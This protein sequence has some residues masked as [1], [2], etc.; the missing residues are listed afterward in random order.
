MSLPVGTEMVQFPTYRLMRLYIQRTMVR[1]YPNR[2]TPFGYRRI[3]GC[4]PL[5]VAFRSLPRPS[6]PDSPKA[7]TMNSYS[8]DHIHR[9]RR[10]AEGISPTLR[11]VFFLRS[12]KCTESRQGKPLATR[13]VL[14]NIIARAHIGHRCTLHIATRALS[15][16]FFTKKLR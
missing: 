10:I 6:S 9:S 8:L 2:V 1:F 5:P 4:V 7:S 3:T 13:T 14:L 15:E 11:Q 12:K 16:V